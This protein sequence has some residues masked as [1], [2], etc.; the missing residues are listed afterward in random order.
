MT[1]N[2]WEEKG[3]LYSS[4]ELN[5]QEEETFAAHIRQCS[6]CAREW[7]RYRHEREHLF[8]I[9]ILGENPSAAC[10]AEILRV[11]SKGTRRSTTISTFSLFLKKS[12]ISL[13]LFV[14]GFTVVGYLVFRADLLEERKTDVGMEKE[15]EDPTRSTTAVTEAA[16]DKQHDTLADSVHHDSIN[17]AN[18]RGNLELKGVYPVDLQNK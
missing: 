6:E 4:G 12:A 7:E 17:F 3:L 11:C 10:D 15:A 18:R 16:M 14:I 13:T 5:R 8:S 9:E 2:L 1:C